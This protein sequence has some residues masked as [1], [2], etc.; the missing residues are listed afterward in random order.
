MKHPLDEVV[1]PL[2][3]QAGDPPRG[4]LNG[5]KIAQSM[6]CMYE[7]VSELYVLVEAL[8]AR[9]AELEE[10][11]AKPRTRRKVVTDPEVDTLDT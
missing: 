6:S 5:A 3:R 8:Q 2:S 1:A 9:V 11:P 7:D 10:K 4:W